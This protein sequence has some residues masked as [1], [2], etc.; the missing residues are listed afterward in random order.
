M[1]R[2]HVYDPLVLGNLQFWKMRMNQRRSAGIGVHVK[3]WSVS[4]R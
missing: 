4:S 3:Q 2:F 1:M